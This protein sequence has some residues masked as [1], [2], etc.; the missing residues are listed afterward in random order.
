MMVLDHQKNVSLQLLQDISSDLQAL[1]MSPEQ[2]SGV[3]APGRKIGSVVGTLTALGHRLIMDMS[4]PQGPS[5][6]TWT[7]C[8]PISAWSGHIS[9]QQAGSGLIFLLCSILPA[10]RSIFFPAV[11]CGATFLQTGNSFSG[12]GAV[13]STASLP[14]CQSFPIYHSSYSTIC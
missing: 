9:A 5:C 12:N 7:H 11:L 1:E 8:D 6:R 14:Q 3:L 10:K 2:V 13:S 4:I